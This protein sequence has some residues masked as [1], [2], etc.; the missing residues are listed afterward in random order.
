M[1]LRT[2]VKRAMITGKFQIISFGKSSVPLLSVHVALAALLCSFQQS[3]NF[4]CHTFHAILLFVNFPV[5]FHFISSPSFSLLF[6]LHQTKV[7]VVCEDEPGHQGWV[8]ALLGRLE[9]RG[10][11]GVLHHGPAQVHHTGHPIHSTTGSL[12]APTLS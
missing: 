12:S 7:H 8:P 10:Y 11:G 9:S 4:L 3:N 2:H 1:C 5:S 6:Y